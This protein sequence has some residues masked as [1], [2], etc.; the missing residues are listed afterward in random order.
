MAK[1]LI[2]YTAVQNK[3]FFGQMMRSVKGF[4]GR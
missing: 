2:V 1:A 3:S 4:G